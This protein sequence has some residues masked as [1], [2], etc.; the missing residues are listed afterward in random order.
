MYAYWE[1]NNVAL[2]VGA[3]LNPRYKHRMVELYI[4][5][6][7]DIDKVELEKLVFM[8]VINELFT[9]Y[10]SDITAKSPTKTLKGASSK[11][12]EF[13]PH[14][15]TLVDEMMMRLTLM[16]CMQQQAMTRRC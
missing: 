15:N 12:S 16:S 7:Y 6:M 3:F 8:N 2:A 13:V 10:S 5:K 9:Y 4:S 11:E 1:M 14:K